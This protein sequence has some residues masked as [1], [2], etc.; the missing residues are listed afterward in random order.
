M[1][2]GPTFL[3]QH[4]QPHSPG[5]KDG[6][7]GTLPYLSLLLLPG[8]F[9]PLLPTLRLS[10]PSSPYLR[11]APGPPGSWEGSSS[12]EELYFFAPAVF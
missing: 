4:E 3:L 5:G 1:A 8:P 6:T 2:A 10:S 7:H 11:W 12:S 9:S